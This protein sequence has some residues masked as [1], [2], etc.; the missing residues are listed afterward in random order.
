LSMTGVQVLP[1]QAPRR[2]GAP[3]TKS[4]SSRHQNI[5]WTIN[6]WELKQ[7]YLK[8]VSLE[9]RIINSAYLL[10]P[11][12]ILYIWKQDYIKSAATAIM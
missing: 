2:T 1:H 5:C 7:S 8:K 9:S 12:A 11:K 3:C 4:S 6:T 10:A